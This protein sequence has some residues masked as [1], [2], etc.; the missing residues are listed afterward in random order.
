MI[1]RATYRL[2]FHRDFT[3]AHALEIVD[4]L[5]DLGISHVYSSPIGTARAGS[6]HGYDVVDPARINPELGGEEGFRALAA[7][8][9]TRGL[10]I[11]LDIVPNHMA[12][13]GSDNEWWL[14]VLERGEES[15]YARWFDIDWTPADPALHGKL[16]APFLG[17]PYAEV[18]ASG[19]LTLDYEPERDRLSVIAYGTHR[20]PVR[21]EDHAGLLSE[22]GA[23]RFDA[24]AMQRLARFYDGRDE[25]GRARLHRLLERQHYRLAWWRVAGDEINW[26]R[27]FEITE[28]AGLRVEEEA[29]FEAVHALPIRLYHEGLI[30][31]VRVD[32]VDGLSDPTEYCRRL[33]DALEEATA[34]RAA[35]APAGPAY[36]VVEKILAAG[37]RLP[38]EW[39]TDGTS[40]Y[41]Y[42]NEA[43]ALL[44]APEGEAPL[45][46]FWEAVSGRSADFAPEE[47]AAR[48]EIL[49]RSF[50][51]QLEAAVVAF[52]AVARSHLSTR[53]LSAGAIRRALRA[54]L[55]VFPAYRTYGTGDGAP[56]TD[57][58]LRAR[59]AEAAKRMVGPPEE[60]VVDRIVGWMAGEGPGELPLRR[61]AVRRLQQLS[62]PVSAKAV[63]DTAFYR[64]GRLLS[65]TDVGFDPRR[66]AADADHFA[67]ACEERLATFPNALL[68]TAT[69]DHKQGEDVRA[70]LAV[71]SEVPDRWIQQA[72]S[73][74][75][76]PEV[77]GVDVSDSYRLLQTLAGAWPLDLDPTDEAGL[78]ELAAR[79]AAWQTKALREAKLRS[80]WS[81][82]D[83]VYER[84]CEEVVRKLLSPRSDFPGELHDFV[85]LIAPAG[86]V[87]GITQA[88]LRC[89]VPGVPDCYQ[90]TEFWDLS[91]VDPDNRRPV[92]FA[93]RIATLRDPAAQDWR[94]GALKQKSIA[95]ALLLRREH[96]RLFSEG[97]FE[98]VQ[99]SGPR[100]SNVLAFTRRFPGVTLLVAVLRNV[101]QP[102]LGRDELTLPADFFRG[103]CLEV[104]G[105]GSLV[106]EEIFQS[107]V[108]A[109]RIM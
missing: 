25:E 82:S 29:V 34:S 86:A 103:T 90:G 80:S 61:E 60:A 18:L 19:E 93:R 8:L 3:F 98:L 76:R 51:G 89:T 100:A 84:R 27:F 99:A 53:D 47:H 85:S 43:S 5:A 66:F 6:T 83:E 54:L 63:E 56:R 109:L 48:L 101:A 62:A 104:P 102:L 15:A 75:V 2:Q 11:I 105:T 79:A 70:R 72:R 22:A 26:R 31:G 106:V 64:Y 21:R 23:E 91:L 16:L 17:A 42:M 50:S 107:R 49:D 32:H 95:S 68:A 45:N 81:H 69:H 55:A 92:D 9:R 13:G 1:P 65:R 14:E 78:E 77:Q 59:A 71:L 36:L 96:P 97:S 37:E 10:G 20:L 46:H 57:A 74:L 58:P 73:W 30:D 39:R 24:L 41:D 52:H 35:D 44:H 38:R 33:R 28:L 7:A 40:G 94:S 67:R 4:Y 87:N 88:I 12:V 108:S